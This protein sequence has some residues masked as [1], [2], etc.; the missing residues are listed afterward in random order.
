M[1]QRLSIVLLVASLNGPW[2][3]MVSAQENSVIEL[4]APR[5]PGRGDSLEVQIATGPLPLGAR[6]V[7]MTEQGE[8]IG[9]VTSYGVPG[10]A[11]GSSATIPVPQTALAGRRLR[12]H[13]QR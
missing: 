4:S 6:L 10:T 2:M 3:S 5:A 7:V 1:R 13:R 12:L 8:V 9:A 11:S